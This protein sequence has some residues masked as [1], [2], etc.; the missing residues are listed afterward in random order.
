MTFIHQLITDHKI[1]ISLTRVLRFYFVKL[2]EE[3]FSFNYIDPT[4]NL[5]NMKKKKTSN[6]ANKTIFSLFF[7]FLNFTD[8]ERTLKIRT[9]EKKRFSFKFLKLKRNKERLLSGK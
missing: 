8:N 3:N 1:M 7:P 9:R 5:N 4:L 6:L 2:N